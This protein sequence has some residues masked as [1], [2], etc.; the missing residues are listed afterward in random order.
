[1]IIPPWS[2]SF[3]N[4]FRKSKIQIYLSKSI[5]SPSKY[6]PSTAT[7]LCR[8][9][10]Q[11]SKH[12]FILGFRYGHQSRLR[13]FHYLLLA[14]KTRSPG[15]F[16]ESIDQEEVAESQISRI[17]WLLDGI[18]SVFGQKVAENDG[19]VRPRVTWFPQIRALLA[20]CFTQMSW[21]D[22]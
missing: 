19:M 15:R 22:S 6:S 21:T 5:L 4:L 7:H 14:A 12:F 3:R 1:M 13:F 10:I 20:N 18:G 8:R 11:T 9:L 17:R 16:F 2:K